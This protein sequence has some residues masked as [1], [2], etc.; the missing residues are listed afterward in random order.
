MGWE[1]RGNRSYYY[2]KERRGKRVVSTYYG[3]GE[4]ARL[5]AKHQ[6]LRSEMFDFEGFEKREQRRAEIEEAKAVDAFLDFIH[7]VAR[8]ALRSTLK[9]AGYHEH[10]GQWRKR[11][12]GKSVCTHRK[13][14]PDKG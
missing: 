7:D 14:E 12:S 4:V 5:V 6:E 9:E 11:R 2:V 10:K 8:V 1:Q 13:E 3:C